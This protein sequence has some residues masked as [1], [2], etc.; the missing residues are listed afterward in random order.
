VFV[1]AEEGRT[2]VT[3]VSPRTWRLAASR[4]ARAFPCIGAAGAPTLAEAS[5]DTLSDLF[6]ARVA[7]RVTAAAAAWRA[8][9]GRREEPPGRA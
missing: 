6:G 3:A 8:A 9:W 2:L 7:A 1:D 5:A 4:P